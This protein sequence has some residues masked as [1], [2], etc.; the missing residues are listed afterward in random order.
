MKI[1][2]FDFNAIKD[3]KSPWV[4]TY[5][6]IM[7]GLQ[8]PLHFFFPSLD[9]SF[10]WLFPS[11]QR[12]HKELTRFLDM[13]SEVIKKKRKDIANNVHNDSLPEN[14]KDVLTLLIEAEQRGE[15]GLTDEELRVSIIHAKK[16]K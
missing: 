14:E 3:D 10:I 9:Q 2:G 11:R 8:H 1:I 15:G 13:L 12:I 4:H 6:T 7:N 16:K 5:N